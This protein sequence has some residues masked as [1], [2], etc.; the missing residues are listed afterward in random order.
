MR[1][2]CPRTARPA[3]LFWG[4][5]RL[6]LESPGSDS[7]PAGVERLTHLAKLW[8]TVRFLHPYLAYKEID[9]DAAL[10]RAIPAVRSARTPQEYAAAVQ[11]ML[12][13]LGDPVTRVEPVGHRSS[14]RP[15]ASLRPCSPG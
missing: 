8:G 6:S 15:P 9:W 14:R 1:P 11:G 10:V 3:G 5:R 13:A 7:Q 4:S 2:P 12:A